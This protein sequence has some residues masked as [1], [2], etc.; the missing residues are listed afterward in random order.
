M[1]G[2]SPAALG[3][4]AEVIPLGLSSA[5]QG[6]LNDALVG[7]HSIYVTVALLN[8]SGAKLSDLS[9][10]LLDGQVNVD[11][12]AEVTRSCTLSLLDPDRSMA[13]DSTSPSDG[14]IYLD[15][16]IQVNYSV[17][18]RAMSAWATIPV[19]TGPVVKMS[20]TDDVVNVECQGKELLGMS[21]VWL[22]RTYPKGWKK[23]DVIQSILQTRAGETKFSFPEYTAQLPAS[24]AIGRLNTPWGVAKHLADGMGLQL[25]YDGRGT[26]RLRSRPQVSTWRFKA[27][28]GGSVTAAPQI[29]Y[30]IDDLKN[31]VWVHGSINP[32]GGL[33]EYKIGAV[34]T[35]PAA[36]ALSATK[37]GRN[38]V[39]RYLVQEYVN[40]SITTQAEAQRFANSILASKQ[41]QSVDV[42]FESL[43]IPHMDPMDVARLDIDQ[44]SAAFR[45]T[46]WSIPLV[47]GSSMSVGFLNRVNARERIYKLARMT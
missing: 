42:Q 38:G 7:D 2:V 23:R 10:R 17:K 22:P 24:Y 29:A 32:G 27:G 20:R 18:S 47:V 36:N 31:T 43:P 30:T 37:L 28:N 25:F 39:P 45:M 16:M 33:S 35:T 9:W 34:A 21:E 3:R 26:C 1:Q 13:F 11:A 14:A 41:M 8:L 6:L 46:R 44:Y 12:D 40:S 5:N 15:R 4:G 19:F